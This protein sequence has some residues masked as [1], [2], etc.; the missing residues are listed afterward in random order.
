MWEDAQRFQIEVYAFGVFVALGMA[1]ALIALALLLRKAAWKKGTAPLTG[2]LAMTAG[3]AVSRLFLCFLAQN[4]LSGPMPI[5]GVF[6]VTAGGYSMMGALLGASMGAV[7]A[8]RITRQSP[9]RLLDYLAPCLMLFVIFE[10]LGEGYGE[11]GGLF[12]VSRPLTSSFLA[13]SFL[14]V[15]SG[16]ESYLA[17]YYLEAAAALALALALLLDL[18][19]TRR[20]GDTYV[21]MLLLFGGAQVV[22]ESIRHDGH[23]VRTL[24]SFVHVQHVIAILMVLAAVIVLCGRRRMKMRDALATAAVSVLLCAGLALGLFLLSRHHPSSVLAEALIYIFAAL[25]PVAAGVWGVV[26]SIR[27]KKCLPC[28][29]LAS[30]LLT[31]GFCVGTEFGIDGAPVG[32]PMLFMLYA[33]AVA[34]PVCLGILLR[35]EEAGYGK[36]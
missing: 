22:F 35:R 30:V 4:N 16:S 10:R 8:A 26:C 25:I 19:R 5:Q 34:V 23:M 14:A 31:A 36:A 27:K 2:L 1:A 13:S 15:H 18:R 20:P 11:T 33:I 29:A 32:R 21:L 3:F 9:A 6:M 17:V 28:L 24:N 7:A 12:G